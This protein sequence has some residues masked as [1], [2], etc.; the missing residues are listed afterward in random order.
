MA[1]ALKYFTL[2]KSKVTIWEK[3]LKAG[4]VF[5]YL[6]LDQSQI[7]QNQAE[8]LEKLIKYY[9]LV[10]SVKLKKTTKTYQISYS[11]R[12]G[13]KAQ[14]SDET[15]LEM[16]DDKLA[17]FGYDD[18]KNQAVGTRGK[19]M[20]GTY[21]ST[22][23]STIK[24]TKPATADYEVGDYLYHQTEPQKKYP[25]LEISG[26]IVTYGDANEPFVIAKDN[27]DKNVLSGKWVIE[28]AQVSQPYQV[29]DLFYRKQDPSRKY[30]IYSIANNKVSYGI[31]SSNKPSHEK[32]KDDFERKLDMG[33]WVIEKA[34]PEVKEGQYYIDFTNKGTLLKVT[35]VQTSVKPVRIFYTTNGN[36]RNEDFLVDFEKNISNGNYVLYVPSGGDEWKMFTSL[37]A[38]YMGSVRILSTSSTEVVL[39]SYDKSGNYENTYTSEIIKFCDE[40]VENGLIFSQS[41][42]QV[43]QP[44]T[45]QT[46]Q[47][48]ESGD[49]IVTFEGYPRVIVTYSDKFVVL[50]YYEQGQKKDLS[51]GIDDFNND[52]KEGL[53]SIYLPSIAD[54][55]DSTSYTT[56]IFDIQ[57]NILSLKITN[58]ET[59]YTFKTSTGRNEFT[60][61]V[62][63]DA[64]YRLVSKGGQVAQPT[65]EPKTEYEQEAEQFAKS[66]DPKYSEK[67]KLKKELKDLVELKD[68]ISDIDFEDKVNVS[69]LIIKTQNKINDIIAKEVEQRIGET[70]IIDELFEQSFTPL[71][72]RYDD[73]MEKNDLI[74]LVAPNGQMS[75]LNEDITNLVNSELFKEW[76]GDFK[77][78]YFYRNL[79]DF[80]GI[81]VS[82]VLS[83]K[84]EPLVLWHGT[85][86]QFSY[87]RFD[88]FPAAYFAVNRKYSDFFATARGGEGYVL[89]FFVNITNPL[90]L[91]IFGIDSVKPK[92]FFDWMYLK[93]GMTPEELEVNPIMIEP[94]MK[95]IPIWMYLRNNISMLKKIAEMGVYDGIK[96]YE[97]NPNIDP[98]DEAYQTLAY[99][100]FSPHQSK[101]AD[102]DRGQIMLASLK[103]FMLKKGGKV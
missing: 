20:I 81:R 102:P 10:S 66:K 21:A 80:G 101:L 57:G 38:S 64:N 43:A 78:A 2:P 75:D 12:N 31:Q 14:S 39:A 87:F 22:G 19:K 84:F 28:K 53:L 89:P 96:F 25:I 49:L 55:W 16:L 48:W 4:G 54:V 60:Q 71:L 29:G 98:N 32:S 76:F 56:E 88:N 63:S 93:T 82:K 33:I 34:K 36:N 6:Y 100:T 40:L 51:V 86:K 73:K 70:K 9:S 58:K 11:Y 24:V 72:S 26:N 74:E 99:I 37:G 59:N 97:F 62:I 65:S 17:S 52:L 61:R 85:N 30:K 42:G 15:M 18:T 3:P 8:D 47:T 103:S 94:S 27:L 45:S 67:S 77:T 13:E 83:E 35:E 79:P 41:G 69:T 92:D 44:Q 91:S 90:D 23:Q 68:L 5:Y 1:S 50:S 46:P 7:D 95:P